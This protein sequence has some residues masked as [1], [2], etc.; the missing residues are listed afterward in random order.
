ML[1]CY[2]NADAVAAA[3]TGKAAVTIGDKGTGHALNKGISNTVTQHSVF[4][5]FT[6]K[7]TYLQI[8][9]KRKT[10]QLATR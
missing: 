5:K 7:F 9:H 4:I 8:L 10:V 2:W 1:K 3:V 6:P